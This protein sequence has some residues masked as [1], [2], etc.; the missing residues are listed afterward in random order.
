MKEKIK[1]GYIFVD[2]S[3]AENC[4][5]YGMKLSLFSNI[6][7]QIRGEPKSGIEG[8][9]SP[10]DSPK[11]KDDKYDIL[12]IN[13]KETKTYVVNELNHKEFCKLEK[14]EF[15]NYMCPKIV[16]YSS[17]MPENIF[18]YNKILDV[19]LIIQN[20]K[21]FY[22]ERKEELSFDNDLSNPTF[23]DIIKR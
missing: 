23:N 14:Y 22:I 12:R 2:K 19:P 15:G 16:I 3:S 8:F 7:L 9:L 21:E 6:N 17:I 20:S 10:K 5:K 11:Y 13:L 18:K 4:C 1:Y